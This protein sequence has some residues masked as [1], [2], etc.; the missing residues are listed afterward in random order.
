MWLSLVIILDIM[1]H[2]D[3][4]GDAWMVIYNIVHY[5]LIIL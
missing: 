1:L 3:L 2:N 5:S 4:S